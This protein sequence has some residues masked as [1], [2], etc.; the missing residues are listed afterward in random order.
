MGSLWNTRR[1]DS[2]VDDTEYGASTTASSISGTGIRGHVFVHFQS[3]MH[4]LEA[5]KNITP[6]LI[7]AKYREISANIRHISGVDLHMPHKLQLCG[8]V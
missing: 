2:A 1:Q 4:A 8:I 7:R 6:G 3:H 5:N